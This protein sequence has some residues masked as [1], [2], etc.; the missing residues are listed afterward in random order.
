MARKIIGI[1]FIVAAII[2]LIFSMIGIG[3]VWGVKAPLTANLL[4][5]LDLIDT[6]L[7]A[8]NAALVVLD[9]T[10]SKATSDVTRL[11]NTIETSS[12]AVDDS[13]PMVE[14]LSDLLS[15]NIPQAIEATQTGISSL[16][17]AAG[18]VESTLALLTSI[19]FLPI[20]KYNPEVS[21]TVALDDVSQS[22]DEIPQSLIEMGNTLNTTRGNLTLLAAQ[23]RIISRNV[24]D[25]KS[26]LYDLQSVLKQY[27]D[28]ITT[29]QEKVAS[30]RV[31]LSTIITVTAWIFT[32]IFIWLGIA[33]IGLL[34]Q[35]LERVNWP[36]TSRTGEG[37]ESPKLESKT[38][39]PALETTPIDEAS[40]PDSEGEVSEE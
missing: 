39:T 10:L 4:N 1:T 33:Q 2:G 38:D 22:L 35:G 6:T 31:N 14:T 21:L 25:L 13:V 27:E 24:S 17:D 8:T 29:I 26:S 32:I 16:Q 23:V 30:L 9:D 20:E 7:D 5:A 3:L 15:V 40:P 36:P 18:T 34:T 28:V 19:P 37:E 12:K 11:E